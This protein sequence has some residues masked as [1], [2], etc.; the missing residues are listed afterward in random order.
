VRR[1]LTITIVAVVAVCLLLAGAV[2]IL[3]TARATREATRRD[4]VGQAQ[5]VSQGILTDEIGSTTRANALNL[6]KRLQ[7][8]LRINDVEIFFIGP[9]GNVRD[10]G[11]K[12][13][14]SPPPG[15]TTRELDLPALEAGATV[16]GH[17]GSLVFAAAPAQVTSAGGV[18]FTQVVLLTRTPASGLKVVGGWFLIAAAISLAA[19]VIAGDRLSRHFTRPL[20]QAE[21][22]TR[23]IAA[24]DLQGQV[25]DPG[26]AVPE[27]ASLVTSINTMADAL[28]RSRGLERQFLL[29]VSHD[30]RTPLTSIRGYAEAIADGA[31]DDPAR[32]AT[33]IASESR[34]LERLV[35]DLLDLAKLDARRFSLDVRRVD[36]AECAQATAAAFQPATAD[37]GLTLEVAADDE[38]AV[39]ADADRLAQVVANLIENA[40]KF[41]AQRIRVGVARA[42]DELA[43]LWVDDDGPGIAAGDL[44]RVFERLYTS[45]RTPARQVGSGLGLAIVSELVGAMGGSVRAESPL[46]DGGGTRVVVTLRLWSE[47]PQ[48][49]QPVSPASPTRPV[50]PPLTD[51][52]R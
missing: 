16:S 45:S 22:V 36:L 48:P 28:A 35:R 39:S 13:V 20:E 51:A 24:G 52:P 8:L 14:A 2:T 23:R 11:S 38:I 3:L 29:S 49:D 12:A 32:A 4:L 18:P 50:P 43:V 21:S 6:L 1:R 30:L 7:P 44:P 40:S 15:F 26:H 46:L 33:V 34:R 25:D 5:A 10:P 31:V 17:R 37:A 41:A 47:L 27:L 42:S 9:G 19:A